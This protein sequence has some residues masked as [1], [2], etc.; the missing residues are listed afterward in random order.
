MCLLNPKQYVVINRETQESQERDR[1]DR[2]RSGEGLTFFFFFLQKV[3]V[4]VKV[5]TVKTKKLT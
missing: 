3:F 5:N 2:H 4:N 1:V